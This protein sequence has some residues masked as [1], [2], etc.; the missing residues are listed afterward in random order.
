MDDFENML[1]NLK[2]LQALNTNVRLD[3]T[4]TLF[5]IHSAGAWVPTFLRR[6]WAEQNRLTDITRIQTLYQDATKLVLDNHPQSIR[7]KRYILDSKKGLSNLKT[8]YRHDPTVLALIDVILDSV[9]GLLSDDSAIDME[10]NDQK[11]EVS[12]P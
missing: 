7:I 2:V 11:I 4:Q 12:G 9:G 10:L 3:T 1:I 6:W 8:T 5:R